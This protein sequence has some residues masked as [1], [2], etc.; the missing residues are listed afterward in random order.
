[1]KRRVNPETVRAM[2]AKRGLLVYKASRGGWYVFLKGMPWDGI[3]Y[4]THDWDRVR[5]F[6]KQMPIL[7]RRE[8]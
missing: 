3:L 6:V 8:Q 1:M 7:E 5:V 4:C 2:A